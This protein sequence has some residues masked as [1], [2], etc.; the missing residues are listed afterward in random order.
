MFNSKD[1]QFYNIFGFK[2]KHFELEIDFEFQI[3]NFEL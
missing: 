2:I 1:I 3:L